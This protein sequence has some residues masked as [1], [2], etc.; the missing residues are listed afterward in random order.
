MPMAR[1]RSLASQP[2]DY[3]ASG[4]DVWPDGDL[5]EDAPA[6]AHF[7]KKLAQRLRAGCGGEG[8]PSIHAI[9]KRADINPQTISNL[10]NGKT[11]GELPTI[12]RVEAALNYELWTHDHLPPI[13]D[14]PHIDGLDT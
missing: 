14:R 12:F 7:A 13:E 8:T 9:A 6:T 2:R 1:R 4:D 5:V 11:W 3:L 10:L